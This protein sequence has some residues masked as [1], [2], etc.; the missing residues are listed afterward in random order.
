MIK[1]LLILVAPL[2]LLSCDTPPEGVSQRDNPPSSNI[3]AD[4]YRFETSTFEKEVVTVKLVTY[5]SVQDFDKEV[6]KRKIKSDGTVVAFAL[7]N[8]PSDICEIHIVKPTARYMPEFMGHE[9]Y[10]CF[11][12]QW[13]K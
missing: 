13:H 4:G 12:G 8:P 9:T 1:R 10:H 3:G 6:A 7:L 5:D 2:L 11:Y